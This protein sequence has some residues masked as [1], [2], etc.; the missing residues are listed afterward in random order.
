LLFVAGVLAVISGVTTILAGA[1]HPSPTDATTMHEA[2]MEMTASSNWDAAHW[3]SLIGFP[4]V[5]VTLALLIEAPHLTGRTTV[6]GLARVAMLG[7]LFM[8]VEAAVHLVSGGERAQLAAGEPTPLLDV[9]QHMQSVGWPWFGL[10][11]AGL[12]LAGIQNKAL[13]G[14]WPGII[15]AVGGVALAMGGL[16]TEGLEVIQAGIL[17]P[18]GMLMSLWLFWVG[19]RLS[20]AALG[21]PTAQHMVP[22]PTTHR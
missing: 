3:A 7:A 8:S 1:L 18:L 6:L 9:S 5:A 13:S 20:R 14:R 4:L 2:V 21:E 11:I 17:F 22:A 12:A 16:L 10:A 19:I 15:G